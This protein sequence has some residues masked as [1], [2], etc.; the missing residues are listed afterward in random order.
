MK[1]LLDKIADDA[2]NKNKKCPK[3]AHCHCHR[4]K[5]LRIN[6]SFLEFPYFLASFEVVF[7]QEIIICKNK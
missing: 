2:E 3:D 6:K 4:R 1:Y 5:E 7:V